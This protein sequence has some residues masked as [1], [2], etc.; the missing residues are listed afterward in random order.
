MMSTDCV[1]PLDIPEDRLDKRDSH[2]SRLDDLS[3]QLIKNCDL[4]KKSRMGK[5]IQ[6]S[7]ND[8]LEQKKPRRKDTPALHTPPPIPGLLSDFSEHFVKS[9]DIAE[10]TQKSKVTSVSQITGQEQKKPRRK[11][12]PAIHIPPLIPGTHLLKEEKQTVIVEDDEKDGEK[13]LI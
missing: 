4:K 1:Q 5:N 3:E 9:H 12:T 6:A 13:A 7:Q 8:E 10:K 2:C 11:D